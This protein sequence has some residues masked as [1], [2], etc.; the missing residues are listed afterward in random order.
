MHPAIH[1]IVTACVCVDENTRGAT[2]VGGLPHRSR[3]SKRQSSSRSSPRATI[4]PSFYNDR[5]IRASR[6][7]GAIGS[8]PAASLSRRIYLR[9]SGGIFGLESD[10]KGQ[11]SII[12]TSEVVFRKGRKGSRLADGLRLAFFTQ[13]LCGRRYFNAPNIAT[14]SL[15]VSLDEECAVRARLC[16]ERASS[17]ARWPDYTHGPKPVI[18]RPVR[19]AGGSAIPGTGLTEVRAVSSVT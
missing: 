16:H 10:L 17:G 14:R 6:W 13:S 18:S 4:L 8:T 15:T 3:G 9:N 12:A 19:Q 11:L 1:V 2:L 5:V 7:T